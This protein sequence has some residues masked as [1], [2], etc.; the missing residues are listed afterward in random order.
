[1]YNSYIDEQG[2]EHKCYYKGPILHQYTR[3]KLGTTIHSVK[4]FVIIACD[5]GAK[6]DEIE[7]LLAEI[8][9][10]DHNN[11]DIK[12]HNGVYCGEFIR[13]DIN[14]IDREYNVYNKNNMLLFVDVLSVEII[15]KIK[16]WSI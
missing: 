3:A 7:W 10:S 6:V 8:N 2:W 9:K 12:T 11:A 15:E 4:D 14:M 5:V 16:V 1:M 13:V